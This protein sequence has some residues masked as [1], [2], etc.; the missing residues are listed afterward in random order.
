MNILCGH[1]VRETALYALVDSQVLPRGSTQKC[2]TMIL[3]GLLGPTVCENAEVHSNVCRWMVASVDTND[4][5]WC[6]GPAID[7]SLPGLPPSL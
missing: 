2:V 4:P 3:V 6:G 5:I 7:C 1:D